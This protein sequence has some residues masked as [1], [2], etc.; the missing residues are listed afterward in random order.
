MLFK[1][2]VGEIATVK[3]SKHF[4]DTKDGAYLEYWQKKAGQRIFIDSVL[5][6]ILDMCEYVLI[7]EGYSI[8]PEDL[9]KDS[10]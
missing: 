7:K 4:K 10:I 6:D 3:S 5:W 8:Y 9:I 2:R 1:F